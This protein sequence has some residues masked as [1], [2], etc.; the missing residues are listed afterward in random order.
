MDCE[1]FSFSE[2]LSSQRIVKA[3]IALGKT[4]VQKIISFA[5]YLLGVDRAT[6]ALQLSIPPGTIRSLVRSFNNKGLAAL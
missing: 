2:K 6:I 4:I 3:E 1:N 5:L